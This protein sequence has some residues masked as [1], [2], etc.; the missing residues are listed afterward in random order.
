MGV[1]QAFTHAPPPMKMVDPLLML[2]DLCVLG[3]SVVSC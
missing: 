2:D 1:A 3:A